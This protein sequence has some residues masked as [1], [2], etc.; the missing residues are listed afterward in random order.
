MNRQAGLTT[1][2]AAASGQTIPQMALRGA[3]NVALR[4]FEHAGVARG[5][6][7]LAKLAE[8]QPNALPGG[9]GEI[10]GNAVRRGTYSAVY[11]QLYHQSPE[12]RALAERAEGGEDLT[13]D[14]DDT[15]LS[16]NDNAT[17]EEQR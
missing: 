16:P 10:L 7:I 12:L 11:Y 3:A 13:A 5:A 2:I 6:D 15:G 17:I 8:R 1:T 9:L 14:N 4:R